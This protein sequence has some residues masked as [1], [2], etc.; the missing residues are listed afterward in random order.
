MVRPEKL[1]GR[2]LDFKG[3]PMF[4]DD[5]DLAGKAKASDI[6]DYYGSQTLRGTLFPSK[7][8]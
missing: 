3:G 8:R 5:S 4:I 1:P 2:H 7:R 6:L